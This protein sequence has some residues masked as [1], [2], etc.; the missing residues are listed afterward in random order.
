M[1][2]KNIKKNNY[3]TFF[4][5]LG[6]FIHLISV[7][8]TVGFYSDDEHF[9]I[10]EIAA[11][12]LGINE[13]A[14]N[15]RTGYYW[16]WEE[17]IR[18][19]PWLQP[20]L[21]FKLISLFKIFYNDPFVWTFLLRFLS[22]IIGFISILYLFFTFKNIFFK[23]NKL[24]NYF[25]FFSFWFYPF[26]HSRTSSENISLSIYIISF[27]ILF[28]FISEKKLSFNIY[29]FS[30][31][32]FLLGISMVF[33]FTTV[34]SALP[35]FFWFLIFSFN[36]KRL[37]IFCTLILVAL[38]IGL[39][40]DYYNWGFF[41]NTY[42][43]FY[44]HNLS[45]GEYGRMKYFGVQPW[46]QYFI[47]ILKE[48]AP[49]S[50]VFFLFGLTIYWFKNPKKL[51]TFITLFTLVVFSLIGHK[52]LRYIFPI[53]IF[54]PFFI[55]YFI[56]I[57]K[58][59]K[60]IISIKSITI[61]SNIIFLLLTLFFPANSKVGVY[62]YLFDNYEKDIPVYYIGENPYQV[63][64]MEPFFYTKY[65]PQIEE[66][67]LQKIK[68]KKFLIASND[69]EKFNSH[70]NLE[71]VNIYSTYPSSIINLNNNWRRLKINWNVYKCSIF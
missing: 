47:E 40:I 66:Y 8:F 57:F 52:E 42:Y 48:L 29:Y 20:F 36:F 10:L 16:E 35:I 23:N 3:L 7:Y 49:P 64:N 43:Q 11:Y 5:L 1:H 15:D 61:F 58:N 39:F 51:L 45:E 69:F 41:T 33:K 38:S 2:F 31:A 4:I 14:I 37:L 67:N 18:M 9:Q 50:S 68:S 25:Y 53:Y 17:K 59:Q 70:K 56:D 32:S 54:A 60:L 62:K 30:L 21:Y 28:K 26:L 71:C 34:F 65:L 55:A 63:N 44:F 22:S 24:Y 27:C 13:I 46:Y 19:R 12:K 6:I